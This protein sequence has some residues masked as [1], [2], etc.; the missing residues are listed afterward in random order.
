MLALGKKIIIRLI[1]QPGIIHTDPRPVVGCGGIAPDVG[2]FL[3][4]LCRVVVGGSVCEMP[5]AGILSSDK[6][7]LE[8]AEPVGCMLLTFFFVTNIVKV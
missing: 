2:R 1:S 4:P 5:H 6:G 7:L 8:G 3:G